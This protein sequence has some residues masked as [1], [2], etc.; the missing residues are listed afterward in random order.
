MPLTG[1]A[2]K[3]PEIVR[4][5]ADGASLLAIGRK[6]G[7]SRE[8]V[9]QVLKAHGFQDIPAH[10]CEVCG[11]QITSGK[12]CRLHRKPT[13]PSC[14]GPLV[15]R[16]SQCPA[17]AGRDRRQLDYGLIA[18]LYSLGYSI[19]QI[20]KAIGCQPMTVHRILRKL[21][22]PTRPVGCAIAQQ[23]RNQSLPPIAEAIERI[24]SEIV[25]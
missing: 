17:C 22:V 7:V 13:C 16:D 15:K 1:I 20:C 14:G 18:E 12:R 5:R 21:E 23:K 4:M 10:R 3:L 2:I 11:V 19:A 8:R 6:F 25:E 24:R 9:R